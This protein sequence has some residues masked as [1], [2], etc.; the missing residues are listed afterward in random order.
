MFLNPRRSVVDVVQSVGRVMRLATGKKYGYIILPVVVPSGVAPEKALDDNKNFQV[1]WDVLQALRAHD[2]RFD[3]M[4]NKVELNRSRDDKIDVIGVGFPG[5]DESGGDAG[6]NADTGSYT[7]AALNLRLSKMEDLR[8]AIYARMVKKVGSRHYWDQWAKDIA[9]IAKAHID[10]IT[11][12]VENPDTAA[13]EQFEVFLDALRRNLN[14]SITRDDAIEMLAQH[15]ITKPVFDALF[16]EYAFT[17]S[18]P[19]SKVMDL[20]VDS[21]TAM[22]VDAEAESLEKFYDSV[23]LRAAGIDNAEGKQKIITELYESFFKNAFPRAAD[24]MGVVYT[25]I[26]IVDFII[27]SVND[28]LKQEF[29]RSISDEGVHVLETFMPHWIQTRANYDLVA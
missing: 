23:R 14:E 20:M 28:V 27:R 18:N 11:T 3:A 2:E 19:V 29:G 5:D 22:H 8:N 17:E 4:V 9:V 6:A 1:V 26:E 15:M 7:Q 25:P 13:S 21:L 12:L 16:E 10:R 24:A